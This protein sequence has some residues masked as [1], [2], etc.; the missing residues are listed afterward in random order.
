[1]APAGSGSTTETGGTNGDKGGG[2]IES[3]MRGV[4]SGNVGNW[5]GNRGTTEIGAEEN[6]PTELR[7]L[8]KSSRPGNCAGSV[9]VLMN[10]KLLA[11]PS[12]DAAD[13]FFVPIPPLS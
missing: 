3:S 5:A 10:P 13:F 11:T 9:G 1:M 4:G 8:V 12:T 2:L 6:A 7:K